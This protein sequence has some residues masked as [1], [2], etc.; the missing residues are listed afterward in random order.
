M[1]FV[2]DAPN[3]LNFETSNF[4]IKKLKEFKSLKKKLK[5]SL[6]DMLFLLPASN[7]KKCI[8]YFRYLRAFI[9]IF[10][11]PN[12]TCLE[13]GTNKNVL[14]FCDLTAKL[15]YSYYTCFIYKPQVQDKMISKRQCTYCS[16]VFLIKMLSIHQLALGMLVFI[17]SKMKDVS[18][19]NPHTHSH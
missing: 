14:I 16:F 5:E 2:D 9:F 3:K 17:F 19:S 11:P 18:S 1:L 15:L 8:L 4:K 12:T 13:K 6:N 10:P 7:H